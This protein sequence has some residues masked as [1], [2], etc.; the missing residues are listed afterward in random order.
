M[1]SKGKGGDEKSRLYLL[2]FSLNSKGIKL[3][4]E[5]RDKKIFFNA[6]LYR[7]FLE[8]RYLSNIYNF[9][10]D[11]FNEIIDEKIQNITQR[12]LKKKNVIE[13]TY[14]VLQIE[15][16]IYLSVIK[17]GKKF[18]LNVFREE[19]KEIIELCNRNKVENI[20]ETYSK[21]FGDTEKFIKYLEDKS[22]YSID[23]S[24]KSFIGLVS[25]L[26]LIE[27][28]Q[29]FTIKEIYL[30]NR[31][32]KMEEKEVFGD[33]FKLIDNYFDNKIDSLDRISIFLILKRHIYFKNDFKLKNNEKNIIVYDIFQRLILEEV[34][35]ELKVRE[36]EIYDLVSTYTLK[37]YLQDNSVKNILIFEKIDLEEFIEIKGKITV[38]EATFPLEEVDYFEIKKI[39]R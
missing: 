16:L 8:R 20:F 26:K 39:L 4:G 12:I 1:W 29:Q 33:L 7:I 15:I 13:H 30:I 22:G 10:F 19:I 21:E 2:L 9:L 11:S 18:T 31:K 35:E 3:V 5:E 34:E 38:I 14:I 25:R 17:N 6:L 27:F 37:I 36:I 32:F 23:L 24:K 28:K